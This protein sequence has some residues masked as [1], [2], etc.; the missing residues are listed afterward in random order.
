MKTF[1]EKY[2]LSLPLLFIIVLLGAFSADAGPA[3][4]GVAVSSASHET[5]AK[6]SDEPAAAEYPP[7]VMQE[8][9]DDIRAIVEDY[10]RRDIQLK[11]A[12]F[13]E[14]PR[15]GRVLK[16]NFDRVETK[17]G[18]EKNRTVRT[19][20]KD[21]AGAVYDVDF[22]LEGAQWGGLDVMRIVLKKAGGREIG[23]EKKEA[24]DNNKTASPETEGAE[25][26]P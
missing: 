2:F 18:S 5:Q 7:V 19:A 26:V 3:P 21:V 20:F 9:E 8:T 16:L 10:I 13:L 6:D 4:A 23:T 11:G 12:F 14:D 22:Q 24:D 17:G 1:F 25:T 15:S